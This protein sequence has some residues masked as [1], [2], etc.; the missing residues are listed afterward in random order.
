MDTRPT[1]ILVTT[2]RDQAGFA[3]LARLAAAGQRPRR[4]YVR[5]AEEFDVPLVVDATHL[6]ERGHPLAR[7]LARINLPLGQVAEGFLRRRGY[8]RVVALSE[9]IGLPLAL[10]YKLARSRRDL[11]LVA[12]WVTPWK[13]AVFLHRLKV[14]THLGALVQ[15]ST[16]QQYRAR[17]LGVPPHKLVL[18]PWAADTRFWRPEPQPGPGPADA[19]DL[20]CAV[21][22]E[23]RDYETFVDAVRELPVEAHLAV[24][25]MVF[26]P[27]AS[28]PAPRA[29]GASGRGRGARQPDLESFRALRLTAGYRR[30][31]RW[32]SGS[33][34]AP[35]PPNV[36]VH[37]QLGPPE[38]RRL[39]ARSRFVVLPLHDMDYDVGA[40]AVTEAMAMGKAV[41]LSAIRGQTDY[42]RHCED[43]LLVR[44]RDAAALREAITYLLENPEVAEAMGK[45]GRQRAEE[46]FAIDDFAARL[47][48]VVEADGGCRTRPG[49]CAR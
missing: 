42:V 45:S 19:G 4:E 46:R 30:Q 8:R 6:R 37:T 25:S 14:H 1:A 20:I 11:V 16:L 28:P 39:Y 18:L 9:R 2:Y 5:L 3:E 32:L 40:T 34:G 10:L 36:V 15:T 12:D 41:V 23:Q 31:R 29:P 48:A 21:G 22:W 43:G 13:K 33:Q 38:L 35:L 7:A 47:R 49:A 17:A 27:P 24:G 26:S 44:P